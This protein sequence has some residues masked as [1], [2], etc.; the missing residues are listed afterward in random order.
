[1]D[2]KDNDIKD[3]DGKTFFYQMKYDP[4]SARFEVPLPDPECPGKQ[5]SHR[6]CPSCIRL[7]ILTQRDIPKV[8]YAFYKYIYLRYS[9]LRYDI[10]IRKRQI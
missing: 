4:E 9:Y 1:M 8:Y 7:A 3:I 2:I 10:L 5:I 6:F